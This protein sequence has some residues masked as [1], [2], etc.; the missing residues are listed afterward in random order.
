MLL[1]LGSQWQAHHAIW[2]FRL[3]AY[4]GAPGRVPELADRGTNF[5]AFREIASFL[6][7]RVPNVGMA[8]LHFLGLFCLAY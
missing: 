1:R 2:L 3:A 6:Q 8:L 7:V 5:I 4:S